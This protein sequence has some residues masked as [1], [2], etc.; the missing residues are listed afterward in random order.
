[1]DKQA[2]LD[3]R[4]KAMIV[5]LPDEIRKKLDKIQARTKKSFNKII[6]DAL[7]IYLGQEKL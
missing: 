2:T 7:A 1:M 3:N 5:R 6:I 4:A